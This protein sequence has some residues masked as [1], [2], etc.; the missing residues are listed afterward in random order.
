MTCLH[1]SFC[2]FHT[3]KYSFNPVVRLLHQ[4]SWKEEVLPTR[5]TFSSIVASW[6]CRPNCPPIWH[7]RT[8]AHQMLVPFLWRGTRCFGV[9][10]SAWRKARLCWESQ[11]CYLQTFDMGHRL[12]LQA[13]EV[14]TCTPSQVPLPFLQ[15]RVQ[16]HMR[17]FQLSSVA[18]IHTSPKSDWDIVGGGS[19]FLRSLS[20]K[21]S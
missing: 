21:S 20:S 18:S 4:I 14:S 1:I 11:N 5:E 17:K 3:N 8:S 9:S 6:V 15:P 16:I 13:F 19:G 12:R 2:T 7:V 10:S